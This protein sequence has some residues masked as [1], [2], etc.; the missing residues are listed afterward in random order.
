MSYSIHA[1]EIATFARETMELR[2]ALREVP[3]G[4]QSSG[5]AQSRDRLIT[6][7]EDFL[8]NLPSHF[9]P[10]STTGLRSPGPEAAIPVHR[11][12][13]HQQLWTL[14]L[15]LNR[16]SPLCPDNLAT[17]RLLAHNIIDSQ[18]H[19]QARCAVCGSLSSNERQV[20]NAAIALLISLLF[21]PKGQDAST[22][23]ARHNRLMTRDKVGEAMELLRALPQAPEILSFDNDQPDPSRTYSQLSVGVLEAILELEEKEHTN[24]GEKNNSSAGTTRPGDIDIATHS[25]TQKIMNSL[26][27]FQQNSKIPSAEATSM[28]KRN[29]SQPPDTPVSIPTAEYGPNDLDVLPILSNDSGYD[30]WQFLDSYPLSLSSAEDEFFKGAA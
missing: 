17:S 20:F 10:G 14:F 9:R 23:S 13:L 11:W 19:M 22:P 18:S 28:T 29:T 12:M 2:N 30:F 7:Y 26:K 15:R 24:Y 8:A 3:Q 1:I 21:P 4:E 16:A 27:R 6:R 25:L 5:R